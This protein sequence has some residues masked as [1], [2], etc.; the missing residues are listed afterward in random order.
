LDLALI[1]L[2]CTGIVYALRLSRQLAAMRASRTEME[3]LVIDFNATVTRAERGVQ[4]LKST[5][6]S[7]GDDL[8]KLIEKA[9]GL[10]DELYFLVD[11]ADTIASRL[12]SSASTA[13]RRAAQPQSSTPKTATPEKKTVSAAQRKAIE[14]VVKSPNLSA[15]SSA[16]K[17][18]LRAL[19]KIG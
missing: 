2:L 8:E 16:E 9:G 13:T 11:S 6:R 15:S 4:G 12:T 14:D 19:K 17:E 7:S 3:R 10:R 1:G 18:L 5:A